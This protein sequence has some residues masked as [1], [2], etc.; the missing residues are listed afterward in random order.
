MRMGKKIRAPRS[1]SRRS[2]WCGGWCSR[3]FQ[4]RGTWRWGRMACSTSRIPYCTVWW[5]WTQ[6]MAAWSSTTGSAKER[7][8]FTCRAEWRSSGKSRLV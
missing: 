5:C 1:P 3:V 6:R 8:S 2:A 7:T 4:S